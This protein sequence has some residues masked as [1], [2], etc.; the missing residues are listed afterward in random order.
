MSW[1]WSIV[2]NQLRRKLMFPRLGE[3]GKA[4]SKR[5]K[6]SAGNNSNL[7]HSFLV[8]PS[9]GHDRHDVM[10]SQKITDFVMPSAVM[11]SSPRSGDFFW[12]FFL[13]FQQK[14]IVITCHALTADRQFCHALSRHALRLTPRG[15]Y[16][17]IG[18]SFQFF[19]DRLRETNA[20]K[21]SENR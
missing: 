15:N 2:T 4:D 16:G 10:P 17:T 13:F 8:M 6:A 7:L 21:N 9:R 12:L 1:F 20:V 5:G 3:G 14:N 19:V 11:P 18:I